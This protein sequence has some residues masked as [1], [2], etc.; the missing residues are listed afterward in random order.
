MQTMID[1]FER[2]VRC[3]GEQVS[4]HIQTALASARRPLL[5]QPHQSIPTAPS[6]S[7]TYPLTYSARTT[8]LVGRDHALEA[9]CR[10][11]NDGRGSLWTVISGEAGTGKSRL[12]AELIAMLRDEDEFD[13]DA[14][15]R[16]GQWRAGFLLDS[17]WLGTD[18]LRWQ[19]DSDTLIVIDYARHLV[20]DRLESLSV[21]LHALDTKSAENE[22]RCK[23]RV[24]LIDRLSPNS[25]KGIF[26]QMTR[27]SSAR[28]VI[29][30]TQWKA[31]TAKNTPSVE[32]S[33]WYDSHSQDCDP[34]FLQPLGST[35]ALE[36]ACAYSRRPLTELESIRVRCQSTVGWLIKLSV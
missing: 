22:L 8:A 32:P 27:G 6:V 34:L 11:I 24:I 23:I 12:A 36:I 26:R 17:L 25:E 10:F 35:S 28:A 33:S 20:A 3:L 4:G 31:S 16:P 18:G 13:G 14:A 5:T 1:S 15:V 29:E 19:P 30:R 2:K 21:F 7:S 9:V